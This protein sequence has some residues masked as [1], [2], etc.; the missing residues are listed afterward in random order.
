MLFGC[1]SL[2]NV[3]EQKNNKAYDS[4]EI[5]PGKIPINYYSD[6]SVK[7]LEVP[8][9][10]TKPN[11]QNS[12]R[13]SE[14]AIGINENIIEFS[15]SEK[16][17]SK[18]TR[19]IRATDE[20]RVEKS[21]NRRWLVIKKDSDT[22][23][24]LA[25]EFL[26]QR[27]FVIK[28]SNKKIGIMETDFL[29]NYPELPQ[30]NIGFIRKYLQEALKARYSLP[31]IDKYRVRI[32]PKENGYTELHLSLFSMQEKLSSSGNIESTIWEAYDKDI[33]L[34]TEM[35]YELM[36]FLGGE[37]AV[38]RE[39]ILNAKEASTIKIKI[40]KNFNGF[41][42]LIINTDIIDAWD[43]INWALDQLNIDIE[44]KDIKEKSFYIK[45]VRTADIGFVSSL[46]GTDALIKTY[47]ILL[48]SISEKETEVYFNDISS[49]NEQ[50][51]K[52]YSHEFMTNIQKLF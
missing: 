48:K 13:I 5:D 9:D 37:Q 24:D 38:A 1:F 18:A 11:V 40:E 15:G 17:K 22:V 32:E 29:E 3:G 14:Y 25:K 44:D 50:E 16:E 41:S 34:E 23:W 36:L 45:A 4:N 6:K 21:N 26:K 30:K 49:E 52:D 47:Q 28:K 8:P 12:F 2:S 10:L 20:I 35:L 27:G 19:I 7:S 46:L 51:T 43:N 42:K 39:R 31:I 33:A